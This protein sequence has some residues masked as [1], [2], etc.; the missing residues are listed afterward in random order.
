MRPTIVIGLGNPL[1]SDE[2]IGIHVVRALAA[3]AGEFPHV[4]F[5]DAGTSGMNALHAMAG[6]RKAIFVDCAFMEAAPG[7]ILQ[8]DPANVS[9]R[10]GLGRLSLHEGDLLD[11]IEL[12]RRLGECPAELVVF[13]IQPER[14]EPAEMLSN[15]LALRMADYAEAVCA[16]LRRFPLFR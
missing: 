4:D 1:M 12:S 8:F 16:E 13:G 15:T 2:G 11:M 3:R 7:T 14:V 10:K 6:R 9:S 5:L